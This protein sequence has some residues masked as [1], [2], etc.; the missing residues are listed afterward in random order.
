[1]GH[2]LPARLWYTQE[3]PSSTR[4]GPQVGF[5]H[6]AFCR[7]AFWTSPWRQAGTLELAWPSLLATAAPQIVRS[8]YSCS[9]SARPGLGWVCRY[10]VRTLHVGLKFG[11]VWEVSMVGPRDGAPQVHRWGKWRCLWRRRTICPQW[12]GGHSWVNV[13]SRCW[14]KGCRLCRGVVKVRN[15]S[16]GSVTVLL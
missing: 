11:N 10:V 7:S 14:C 13:A 2:T 12:G 3:V 1:M 6:T 16:A 8:V 15:E 9:H 5:Q 4:L